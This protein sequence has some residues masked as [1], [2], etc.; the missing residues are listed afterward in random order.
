MWRKTMFVLLQTTLLLQSVI[1]LDSVPEPPEYI[2][3]FPTGSNPLNIK[4]DTAHPEN[5]YFILLGDW[6]C[7]GQ[8][9]VGVKMQEC[10]ANQ[11]INFVNSQTSKGMNLLFIGTVGDNFYPAG[12]S[13]IPHDPGWG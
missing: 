11:M 12:Q 4:V 3:S 7:A 2:L 8:D 6:G 13:C 10:I 5:N 1:S 9:T